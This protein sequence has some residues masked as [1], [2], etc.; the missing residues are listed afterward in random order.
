MIDVQ[1]L[2]SAFR[3]EFSTEP[4]IFHAPGRV[5]LIGEH[6]DYNDGFVLP[7]ALNRGTTVAIAPRGDRKLRVHSKVLDRK[8]DLDLDNPGKPQRGTWLD[9]V[10]GTAQQLMIRG[11]EIPGADL[12]IH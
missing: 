6:T 7:I 10:E 4:R 11:V 8:G 3:S 5:N 2:R 1:A 12:L 9:Y